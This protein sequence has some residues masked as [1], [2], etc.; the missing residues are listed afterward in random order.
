MC[1]LAEA[2]VPSSRFGDARG[3]VHALPAQE[4][5]LVVM[6]GAMAYSWHRYLCAHCSGDS[7]WVFLGLCV[8][9]GWELS[10]GVA[11]IGGRGGVR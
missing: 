8:R 4:S 1:F 7:A 11:G 9:G 2:E 5:S 10:L 3:S 6:Q